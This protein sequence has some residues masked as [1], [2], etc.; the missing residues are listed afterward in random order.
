MN[1]VT[2]VETQCF[3]SLSG[4]ELRRKAL[5]LYI[6]GIKYHNAKNPSGQSVILSYQTLSIHYLLTTGCTTE[7]N[8]QNKRQAKTKCYILMLN[9]E[10]MIPEKEMY[11]NELKNR[12]TDHWD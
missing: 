9:N 5:R 12:L 2:L 4:I 10:K 3:A 8:R 1:L 11:N 6:D 7:N